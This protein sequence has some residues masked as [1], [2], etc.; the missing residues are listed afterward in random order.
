ML[1]GLNF[2]YNLFKFGERLC[3]INT[4]LLL[5]FFPGTLQGFNLILL[6]GGKYATI[7]KM[8]WWPLATD[9]KV[10]NFADCYKLPG[11]HSYPLPGVF[12]STICL[13][14]SAG[15]L[16]GQFTNRPTDWHI[17][18]KTRPVSLMTA[19]ILLRETGPQRKKIMKEIILLAILQIWHLGWILFCVWCTP[20]SCKSVA[21][22]VSSFSDCYRL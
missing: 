13:D 9:L 4:F 1:V 17:C 11:Y 21:R 22:N 14:W 3:V 8:C 19:D 12:S 5:Y 15:Q 7:R 10:G 2:S 18:L 20:I 16:T 6:L